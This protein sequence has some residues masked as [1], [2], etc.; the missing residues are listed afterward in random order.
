MLILLFSFFTWLHTVPICRR[1]SALEDKVGIYLKFPLGR[2]RANPSPPRHRQDS[3]FPEQGTC[4]LERV[5]KKRFQEKLLGILENFL[6]GAWTERGR[7][8]N[9]KEAGLLRLR[10]GEL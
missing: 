8:A 7:M 9:E 1:L 6:E 10:E 5:I 3:H 2:Q 4:V